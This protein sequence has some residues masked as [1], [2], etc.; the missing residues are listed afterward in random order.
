MKICYWKFEGILNTRVPLWVQQHMVDRHYSLHL[1]PWSA[2]TLYVY[3]D[4]AGNF[5]LQVVLPG[6]TFFPSLLGVTWWNTVS[7]VRTLKRRDWYR[8]YWWVWVSFLWSRCSQ[9]EKYWNTA[10]KVTH[11]SQ[12]SNKQSVYLAFINSPER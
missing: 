10:R 4:S 1:K 3:A 2:R 7:Y 12:F 6:R 8:R 5:C 9:L 11:I